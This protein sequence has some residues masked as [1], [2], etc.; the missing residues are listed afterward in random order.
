MTICGAGWINDKSYG[1]WHADTRLEYASLK[2]IRSTEIDIFSYPVKHFGR[3]DR[4]SKFACVSVALALKDAALHYGPGN[5][6]NI[7]LLGTNQV[8]AVPANAD[9]FKDFV[10]CGRTLGRGNLFIYTL[11]SSPLA[12]VSI[13]FDL[14]GPLL[15]A[16]NVA[17]DMRDMMQTCSLLITDGQAERMLLV[18]YTE[19]GGF[20]C[21]LDDELNSSISDLDTIKTIPHIAGLL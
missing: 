14:C 4:P 3:F 1:M 11:P 17:D 16:A 5:K 10:D 12:E 13:H 8:G 18:R 9:Y 19:P 15:Y 7:G 20:A 6:L 2:E 21:L